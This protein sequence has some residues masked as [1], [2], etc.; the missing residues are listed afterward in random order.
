MAILIQS[1]QYGL[2]VQKLQGPHKSLPTNPLIAD[3]MYWKGYIE[4]VGTGTEDIIEKC[5]DYGLKTPEFY[6]EE[7]FRVVIW[8]AAEERQSD[9]KTIQKKQKTLQD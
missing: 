6:Q 1:E 4:K 7:D 3:P 8:R 2:T 9:P 5:R